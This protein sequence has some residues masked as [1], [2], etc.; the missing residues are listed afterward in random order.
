MRAEQGRETRLCVRVCVCVAAAGGKARKEGDV[1]LG[2]GEGCEGGVGGGGINLSLPTFFFP[3][4]AKA[5]P[6]STL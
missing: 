1:P 4:A 5:L 3:T 2:S 6:R